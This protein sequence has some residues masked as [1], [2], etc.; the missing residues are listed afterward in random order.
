ML[1][2]HLLFHVEVDGE[3]LEIESAKITGSEIDLYIRNT[4]IQREPK[5]IGRVARVLA[6]ALPIGV[7]MLRIDGRIRSANGAMARLL[8]TPPRRLAWAV[9]AVLLAGMAPFKISLGITTK[10]W[11]LSSPAA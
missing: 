5:A 2:L 10:C 7:A 11:A 9:I 4:A 8:G 6:L 1:P 3:P